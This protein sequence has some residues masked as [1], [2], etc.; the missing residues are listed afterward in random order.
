MKN[1]NKGCLQ[2]QTQKHASRSLFHIRHGREEYVMQ[3]S[4]LYAAMVLVQYSRI[5]K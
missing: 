5:V 3:G 2:M 4:V 1:K